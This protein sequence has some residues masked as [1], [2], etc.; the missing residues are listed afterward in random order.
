M[1]KVTVIDL[2]H[3]PIE[4]DQVIP[5]HSFMAEIRHARNYNENKL[6]HF[7]GTTFM[8]NTDNNRVYIAKCHTQEKFCRR[9]GVLTCIQKYLGKTAEIIDFALEKDHIK[10]WV[11]MNASANYWFLNPKRWSQSFS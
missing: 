3:A 8:F 6:S 7:G 9:K 2:T 1:L 5:E 11:N 10:V 4:V